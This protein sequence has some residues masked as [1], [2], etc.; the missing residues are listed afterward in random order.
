MLQ[1]GVQLGEPSGYPLYPGVQV[2]VLVVF[3]V[4]VVFVALTLLRG[5]NGC[6]FSAGKKGLVNGLLRGIGFGGIGFGGNSLRDAAVP[7]MGG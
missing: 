6:V 3:R 4:E 1:L 7:S 2:P 5:G